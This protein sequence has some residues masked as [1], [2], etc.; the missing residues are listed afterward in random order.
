MVISPE[1]IFCTTC[2]PPDEETRGFITFTVLKLF[3]LAGEIPEIHAPWNDAFQSFSFWAFA[4]FPIDGGSGG[5][6]NHHPT[7][8][9]S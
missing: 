5:D 3:P 6:F 1:Q 2:P 8:Q 7:G 9:A 4:V